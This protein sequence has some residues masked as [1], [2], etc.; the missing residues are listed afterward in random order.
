MKEGKVKG[1]GENKKKRER[2]ERGEGREKRK[3]GGGEEDWKKR[4]KKIEKQKW[5]D[6]CW[7]DLCIFRNSYRQ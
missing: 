5:I 3:G 4:H 6:V 1:N 2:K 7:K